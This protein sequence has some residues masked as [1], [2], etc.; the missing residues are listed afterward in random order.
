MS[1]TFSKILLWIKL[2]YFLMQILDYTQ[3]NSIEF[4]LSYIINQ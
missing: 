3:L 2:L 1:S 4:E